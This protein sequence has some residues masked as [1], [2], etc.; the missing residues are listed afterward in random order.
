MMITTP[1]L[2]TF[3][4]SQ[5]CVIWQLK[6]HLVTLPY[7]S[8]PIDDYRTMYKLPGHGTTAKRLR[9]YVYPYLIH[10]HGVKYSVLRLK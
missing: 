5:I 7:C 8:A 1:S 4:I 2:P 3:L 6:C 10:S 9:E